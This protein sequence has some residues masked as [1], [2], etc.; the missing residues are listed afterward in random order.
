MK[1]G[2]PTMKKIAWIVVLT[3]LN[4]TAQVTFDTLRKAQDD[5]ASWLSYGKNYY[6]WRYSPL[7]QINAKNIGSL[8]PAWILPTGA[9]GN[10][11]SS[12]IVL[13]GMMYLTGPSNSAWAVDLL[14]GRKVWSYSKYAPPGLGFAAAR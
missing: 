13:D 4:G 11:E 2:K 1:R 3:C 5:P 9:Q 10:N 12:P 6:G 7:A 14:T 8:A